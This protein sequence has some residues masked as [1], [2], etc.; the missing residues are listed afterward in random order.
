ME[1]ADNE[2]AAFADIMSILQKH[3]DFQKYTLKDEV[4]LS[5]PG[6]E[7]RPISWCGI[8]KVDNLSSRIS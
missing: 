2:S 3:S 6:L 1:F 4:I 5:L 7:I 8:K